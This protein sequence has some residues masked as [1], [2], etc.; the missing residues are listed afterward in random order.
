MYER[1]LDLRSLSTTFFENEVV[2][3][4]KGYNFFKIYTVKDN[5][6]KLICIF[7]AN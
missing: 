2:E 3:K 1:Y 7:N 5:S 4:I 6:D